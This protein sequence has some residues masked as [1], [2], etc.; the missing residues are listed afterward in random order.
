MVD[1]IL[2]SE[3][4]RKKERERQQ[5]QEEA[6]AKK[7]KE[8]KTMSLDDLKKT[9]SKKGQDLAGKK[10]KKEDLIHA[11]FAIHKQEEEIA[12]KKAKMQAMGHDQLKKLA[13]S[14][15]ITVD[16]K[17]KIIQAVLAADEK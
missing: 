17:D 7:V 16:K 6:F 5:Q 9:L 10:D 2:A 14:R 15:G 13:V 8:L 4:Q 12:A 1:A 11:L 3:A